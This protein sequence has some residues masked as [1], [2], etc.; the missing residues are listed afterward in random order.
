VWTRQSAGLTPR[1]GKRTKSERGKEANAH[2]QS[3]S[4]TVRVRTGM[5]AVRCVCEREHTVAEAAW[6]SVTGVAQIIISCP[7]P[8]LIIDAPR[9]EHL[10]WN[11]LGCRVQGSGLRA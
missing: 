1:P 2:T 5:Q 9:V 7:H 11:G 6:R 10:A 4:R 3:V 8:G